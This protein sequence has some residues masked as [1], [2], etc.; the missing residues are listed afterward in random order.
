MCTCPAHLPLVAVSPK[1]IKYKIHPPVSL[2]PFQILGRHRWLML[3]CWTAE[4]ESCSII[5]NSTECDHHDEWNVPGHQV[6]PLSAYPMWWWQFVE[7]FP[8]GWVQLRARDKA[9]GT[10]CGSGPMRSQHFSNRMC[11]SPCHNQ[12][13][14]S[15][16]LGNSDFCP[17]SSH[18]IVPHHC[19]MWPCSSPPSLH[20]LT[21]LQGP[22][23]ISPSSSPKPFVS[24]LWA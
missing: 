13:P 24:P 5:A 8:S 4:V 7:V 14:G 23:E 11:W 19:G 22:G 16:R 17:M 1:W 10:G 6:G 2:D 15:K 21:S 3:P 18:T 20:Q 12:A 9:W